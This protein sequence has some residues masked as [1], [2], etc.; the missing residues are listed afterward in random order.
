MGLAIS[1]SELKICCKSLGDI[2]CFREVRSE[3][4]VYR[5]NC[6]RSRSSSAFVPRTETYKENC[7]R[8][9]DVNKV[10][11]EWD[12]EILL[13]MKGLIQSDWVD[14]IIG[15]FISGC[16]KSK[17]AELK[18]FVDKDGLRELGSARSTMLEPSYKYYWRRAG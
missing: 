16:I 1:Q 4:S 12:G 13:V 8:L 2:R 5:N 14:E 10:R 3:D 15:K 6:M 7:V 17:I 18:R 9:N 11:V